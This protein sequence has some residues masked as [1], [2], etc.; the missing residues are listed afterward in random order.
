MDERRL[1]R[2]RRGQV[3]KTNFLFFFKKNILSSP[4]I[5]DE[6]K[7]QIYFIRWDVD[8]QICDAMDKM[9]EK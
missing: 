6:V 4:S 1:L 8:R 7:E 2:P 5:S 9:R 3:L